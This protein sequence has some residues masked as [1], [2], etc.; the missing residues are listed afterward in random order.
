MSTRRLAPLGPV[1][2]V[3]ALVAN[4]QA[5]ATAGPRTPVP[6]RVAPSDARRALD[7]P[8]LDCAI[9]KAD[10]IGDAFHGSLVEIE[11]KNRGRDAVEPLA[12]AITPKKKGAETVEVVRV[13]PPILGRAG[14]LVAPGKRERFRLFVPLD[15]KDVSRADVEVV[16]ASAWPIDS[17]NAEIELDSKC[18]RVGKPRTK[19]EMIQQ[20]GM[21]LPRTDVEL[22][23]TTPYP[24]DAMLEVDFGGRTPGR[25]IVSIRLEPNETRVYSFEQIEIPKVGEFSASGTLGAE[26]SKIELVDWSAVVDDGNALVDSVLGPAWDAWYRVPESVFPL[27]AKFAADVNL[28]GLFGSDGG[29]FDLVEKVAGRAVFAA[30]GTVELRALDGTALRA[31]SLTT[32]ERALGDVARQMS[33]PTFDAFRRTIE[34]EVVRGGE[35]PVFQVTGASDFFSFSEANVLVAGGRLMGSGAPG[36]DLA[37]F[38]TYDVADRR[39]LPTW[40]VVETTSD[41]GS[42]GERT[43]RFEWTRLDGVEVVSKYTL[44][45]DGLL[46]ADPEDVTITLE[47]F[48]ASSAP[49]AELPPPT[50]PLA[51]AL[52]AAWDGAYRYPSRDAHVAGTYRVVTPGTDGVWIGRTE[53]SGSFDLTGFGGGG[54]RRSTTT[55]DEEGATDDERATLANAVDDRIAMWLGRDLCWRE[56]FAT[57]FAGTELAAGD[58]GWIRVTGSR[59][60]RGVRLRDG[61]I[62]EI[63]R[64]QGGRSSYGWSEVGGRLVPSRASNGS[65]VIEYEWREAAD[66]WLFPER[67]RMLRVFGDDWGPEVM[68]FGATGITAE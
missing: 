9:K 56:P 14:R 33:R 65:E 35:R 29:R 11:V 12:F 26:I 22:E 21:V 45:D 2:L 37:L 10:A 18:V 62:L 19:S 60:I 23:N 34:I 53:V 67:V 47:D 15:P 51:E 28:V 61:R 41:M 63:E 40:R 55:V 44:H 64:T 13:A 32:L 54:W 57:T 27:T 1:L 5:R 38:T 43:S 17:P 4:V 48:E 39:A 6:E 52:R 31:K 8:K 59:R 58:D 24:L 42:Q 49:V 46:L 36:P 50:G 16:D 66:G 25:T 68:E 7:E 3:L 30:D 20:F